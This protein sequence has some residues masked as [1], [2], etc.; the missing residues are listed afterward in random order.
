MHVTFDPTKDAANLAKHGVSLLDAAGLEWG[1]ALLWPDTRRDYQEA[2]MIGLALS[3]TDCSA[4]YLLTAHQNSR[5]NA[6]S[7]A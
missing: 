3:T 7:S 2:R 1:D 6:A 4:S 5:Q